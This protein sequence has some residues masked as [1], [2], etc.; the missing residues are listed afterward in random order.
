MSKESLLAKKYLKHLEEGDFESVI[1]MFHPNGIVESPLY[2]IMNAREFYRVLSF[3]TSKSTLQLIEVFTSEVSS[4]I[5]IYFNYH[6]IL[7]NNEQVSFDVVDVIELD[8]NQKI[9]KLKII[10]DTV[11]SRE[12]M[13]RI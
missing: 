5:A 4:L 10:Y 8:S 13:K 7:K 2:G 6:W 11:V 1:S 3:N 9:L 12:L